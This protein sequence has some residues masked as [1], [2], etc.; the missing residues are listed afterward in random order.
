M[1]SAEARPEVAT[2]GGREQHAY[3]HL[4]TLFNV[5]AISAVQTA[6]C[7]S[8]CADGPC[9]VDGRSRGNG[10]A[11]QPRPLSLPKES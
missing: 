1:R 7:T 5:D 11:V 4:R 6:S 2:H 3:L 9:R 10:S 8:G